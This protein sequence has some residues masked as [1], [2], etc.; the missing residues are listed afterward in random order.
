MVFRDEEKHTGLKVP[1]VTPRRDAPVSV[2][3]HPQEGIESL[4]DEA[5]L[6]LIQAR[7]EGHEE[8]G[9]RP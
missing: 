4:E 7:E 1:A 3:G 2:A 9:G 5:I 8:K 6:W